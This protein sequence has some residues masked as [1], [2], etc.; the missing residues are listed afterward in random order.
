MF[1]GVSWLVGGEDNELGIWDTIK[2]VSRASSPS[3]S[4]IT[5]SQRSTQ[6]HSRRSSRLAATSHAY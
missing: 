6:L 2:S 3:D 5:G 1:V 4:D